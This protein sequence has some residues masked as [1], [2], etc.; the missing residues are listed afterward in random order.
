MH[1]THCLY[2]GGAF[3]E[4]LRHLWRGLD[5][6]ADLSLIGCAAMGG[7]PG[8]TTLAVSRVMPRARPII[9]ILQAQQFLLAED[10]PAPSGNMRKLCK[11]DPTA[12]RLEL[13]L[14]SL[15]QR[16]GD[17]KKALAHVRSP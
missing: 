16:Q 14:A 3:L 4:Y 17:V 10:G 7:H 9:I 11:A 13:E 5:P 15:Y 12:A 8:E 6:L 1:I 2:S